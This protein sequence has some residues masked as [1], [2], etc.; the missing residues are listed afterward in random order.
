MMFKQTIILLK[1]QWYQI[2]VVF[3]HA[4]CGDIAVLRIKAS[5]DVN[6]LVYGFSFRFNI[7]LNSA[8]YLRNF[9]LVAFFTKVI[10]CF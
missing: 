10:S 4:W 6:V 2:F 5:F 7:F 8:C 1:A 3:F 9:I